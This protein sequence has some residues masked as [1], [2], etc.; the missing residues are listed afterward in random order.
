VED[1]AKPD[2]PILI[3]DIEPTI[4]EHKGSPFDFVEE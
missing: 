1:R 3:K 4:K 2:S